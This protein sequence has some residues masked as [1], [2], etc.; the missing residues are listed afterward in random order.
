MGG[1]V[2]GRGAGDDG[3]AFPRAFGFPAVMSPS[4]GFSADALGFQ[5]DGSDDESALKLE[6][7]FFFFFRRTK[8][9]GVGNRWR[10]SASFSWKISESSDGFK[11]RIF[12]SCC[13]FSL[14]R[15]TVMACEMRRHLVVR[16]RTGALELLSDP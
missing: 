16:K 9:R 7:L 5:G 2:A 15:L 11:T 12:S 3:G 6:K 14:A 8:L 13:F 10:Q 4:G 1:G